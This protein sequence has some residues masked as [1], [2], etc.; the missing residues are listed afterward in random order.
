MCDKKTKNIIDNPTP[1]SPDAAPKHLDFD[2]PNF[3]D[4]ISIADETEGVE[5]PDDLDRLKKIANE[6][7]ILV[8]GNPHQDAIN[9]ARMMAR[10]LTMPEVI[11]NPQD[12]FG[13]ERAAMIAA[14]VADAV[15]S[16][17]EGARAAL[18]FFREFGIRAND[19]RVDVTIGKRRREKSDR[20]K[21]EKSLNAGFPLSDEN[22]RV[23]SEL[24]EKM[25]PPIGERGLRFGDRGLFF[26]APSLIVS[27]PIARAARSN[28]AFE[29]IKV[30]YQKH[31]ENAPDDLIESEVVR[32]TGFGF[33]R[34]RKLI[35]RKRNALRRAGKTDPTIAEL[36]GAVTFD[37]MV[38]SAQ[39][40]ISVNVD[41]Y[42][43][44]QILNVMTGEKHDENEKQ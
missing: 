38:R 41:S 28:A 13:H 6:K 15:K 44:E 11:M 37:A 20:N 3:V 30:A 16:V 43:R 14:K 26:A 12:T 1:A 40:R 42:L 19:I 24:R 9:F 25:T 17:G 34:V 5:M 22:K 39:K 18:P 33:A 32:M 36:C 7:T 27:E 4:P 2:L 23:L 21:N 10:G 31:F 35:K 29:N 8:I